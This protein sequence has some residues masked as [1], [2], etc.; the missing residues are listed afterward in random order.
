MSSALARSSVE[1]SAFSTE[2]HHRD[3]GDRLQACSGRAAFGTHHFKKG[4]DMGGAEIAHDRGNP[5]AIELLGGDANGDIPLDRLDIDYQGEHGAIGKA[6][7]DGA[8]GK[9]SKQAWHWHSGDLIPTEL[10]G[11]SGLFQDD[12][13]GCA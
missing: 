11:S 5:L 4:F 10:C 7:D 9:K 1:P 3:R 2:E 13:A 12:T 8:Q 6:G